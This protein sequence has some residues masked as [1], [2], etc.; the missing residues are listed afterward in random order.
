M[1]PN[2]ILIA[3]ALAIALSLPA[4]ALSR[5]EI[6][7]VAKGALH[8]AADPASGR[9]FVAHGGMGRAD[10]V[11]L[12]VADPN[13]RVTPIAFGPG[14]THI[15][16]SARLRRAVAVHPSSNQATIV[17]LDTLQARTVITGISPSRAILSEGRGFAYVIGKGPAIETGS[18]SVTEIDLRTGFARTFPL[19]GFSPEGAIAHPAGTR[20]FVFG[21][22]PN[23]SGPG[24]GYIQ[25][26][27]M[28]TRS[29][30]GA[31]APIGHMPRHVLASAHDEEIYVVGHLQVDESL[32]RVLFVM[33]A[34]TLA[35]RRILPLPDA[36]D[37]GRADLDPQTN[38]I[39]LLDP[40]DERLA[41][42]DPASGQWRAVALEAPGAALAVNAITRRVLV[43]FDTL[44][45]A[46]IF[47][48]AGERLDTLSLGRAPAPGKHYIAVDGASGLAHVTNGQMGTVV[49][50]PPPADAEP[51]V[52]DFTD[53]WFDP[54][55]P[56][57]GV[58]IDQQG[59]AA[60]A[61]LFT[62]DPGGHPT[63]LFMSNGLRQPDGSFSGDLH[64]TRGPLAEAV[65]NVAAVGTMRFEPQARDRASLTY[66]V[67][68]GL[69]TRNVKRFRTD[70][71]SRN[72]RWMVDGHKAARD[73]TNF[74]SL[75]S[76]P[77]DPGW[78]LAVSHQGDAAFGVLFTYD[79]H[80][81]ATWAVMS[82]GKLDPQGAFAG[83]V[84]RAVGDRLE[85]VG[86]MSLAFSSA[87]HG[88]L[89]YRL[90]GL[91]FRGPVIR[92]TFG[93]LTSHC[94]S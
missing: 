94:S 72:C 53:L 5:P 93:R 51:A 57:W 80:N 56:G 35:T 85:A 20:L 81:R 25:S 24:A 84:Y 16:L 31:P 11:S 79:E 30:D 22:T 33:D 42:V 29:A 10:G 38:Q 47:S 55:Q 12:S 87:D 41:I 69:H 73:R 90:G 88:V 75:W 48:M 15:A 89:R 13:G 46:G 23:S 71:A 50:V 7:P 65:K 4:A 32:H 37:A 78:G 52:V 59:A 2:Q 9:L 86:H 14:A 27:D 63:W 68:G 76:N 43:S 21:T 83:D 74:T 54:R 39:Y 28:L 58:F 3:C 45:Q 6:L 61:T 66:Y 60:F 62:H 36:S 92:Q 19:P 77:A 67:D 49:R 40:A 82:A 8:A 70:D 1:S 91:D 34:N 44:G 17:D 18:G 64:R 26:F